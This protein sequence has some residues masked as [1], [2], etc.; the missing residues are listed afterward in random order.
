VETDGTRRSSRE[1]AAQLEARQGNAQHVGL[2][3]VGHTYSI[4]FV[5]VP[6]RG[7]WICVSTKTESTANVTLIFIDTFSVNT[8][9]VIVITTKTCSPAREESAG[10]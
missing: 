2:D 5:T 6:R 7:T 1:A 4:V 3:A 10:R 8:R 9:P